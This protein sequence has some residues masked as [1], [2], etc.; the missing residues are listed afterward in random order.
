MSDKEYDTW[1]KGGMEILSILE[2]IAKNAYEK[3]CH[4]DWSAY[5]DIKVLDTQDTF[6][7]HQLCFEAVAHNLITSSKKPRKEGLWKIL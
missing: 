4:G 5:D 3:S 7:L 6:Y 1:S 2:L